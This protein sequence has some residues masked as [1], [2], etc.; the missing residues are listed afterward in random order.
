MMP[1]FHLAEED[2]LTTFVSWLLAFR[3]KLLL[4]CDVHLIY[5]HENYLNL[6]PFEKKHNYKDVRLIFLT[7]YA[8]FGLSFPNVL[9]I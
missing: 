2:L 3:L 1:F 9:I 7:T 6:L 4:G 8:R 5:K